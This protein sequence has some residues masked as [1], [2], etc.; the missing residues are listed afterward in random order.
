MVTRIFHPIGQGAFYSER[1]KNFNIVYDCGEWKDTKLA[2]KVVKQSFNSTDIIDILFISH[3]DFDHVSKIET[4]KNHCRAIKTVVLPLLND[5]E[6]IVL[7]N[8]YR[9]FSLK[10]LVTLIQNPRDF[11]GN[12]TNIIY[13]KPSDDFESK[14]DEFNLDNLKKSNLEKNEI[15]IS[16]K[17]I[18]FSKAVDWIFI[19]FNYEH[20]SRHQEL[21][22]LFLIHK[23]DLEI[24]K[25][26]LSY[27]ILNRATI[28]KIYNSLSGKINQNSML[29]YSGP[30]KNNYKKIESFHQP[31]GR[32]LRILHSR[33]AC[34]YSGDADF[35]FVNIRLIFIRYWDK[36]GTIQ[37]P[38][39]GD[40][41]C[42]HNNFLDHEYICP[43]SVGKTNTFGHPSSHVI[44]EILRH[45]S[46]PILVSEDL[47]SSLIEIIFK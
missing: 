20:N 47:S 42:F 13:I 41:K 6:K 46:H 32:Y 28:K 29:V 25:K 7:S 16:S 17:T 30:K 39:H 18:L 37:I 26:D 10:F 45:E 21:K 44:G 19:P 1:H 27:G 34:I 43:I 15:I 14:E 12:E 23:L 22:R 31:Y 36:V 3:Y 33:V 40:I 9:I 24:F 35:N 8:I 38:H 11:F 5:N 2:D 4:L